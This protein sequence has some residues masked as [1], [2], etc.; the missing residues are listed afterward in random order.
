MKLELLKIFAVSFSGAFFA[1]IFIRFAE[2]LKS[3]RDRKNDDN[4]A[5]S[6][7]QYLC[8][9]NYNT[10]NDTTFSLK[11]SIRI[12]EEAKVRNQAPYSPLLF[13]KL[14]INKDI[15]LKLKNID[16]INDYFSYSIMV[17]KHNDDIESIN[18]FKNSMQTA[19]LSGV[20]SIENY[21]ENMERLKVQFE[22][23][24]KYC[25]DSKERTEDI[26]IKSRVLI[27]MKF[28]WYSKLLSWRKGGYPK[29]YDE[30][31]S[32]ELKLLREELREVQK[33]SEERNN[34]VES[35]AL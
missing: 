5:L 8:N 18:V 28:H 10:L 15:I 33:T 11:D 16:F 23:F 2:K 32:K 29:N 1:F 27:K 13:K 21:L 6:K 12:I 20:I 9:E 4:N 26:L 17:D 31:H 14:S 30:L 35:K 3:R 7:I 22:T 25:E 24:I 19:Q 34:N